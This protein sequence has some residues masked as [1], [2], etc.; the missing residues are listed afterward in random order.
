MKIHTDGAFDLGT[1][2]M[3]LGGVARMQGSFWCCGEADYLSV[4]ARGRINWALS[5]GRTRIIPETDSNV[6]SEATTN[7]QQEVPS[8]ADMTIDARNQTRRINFRAS[9]WVWLGVWLCKGEIIHWCR[10]VICWNKV[11]HQAKNRERE[12]IWRI[13]FWIKRSHHSE[14]FFRSMQRYWGDL[15]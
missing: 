4:C 12:G 5:K 8:M 1:K 14:F 6:V 11:S 2:T 15:E 9:I 13:F 10:A 3:G 7:P